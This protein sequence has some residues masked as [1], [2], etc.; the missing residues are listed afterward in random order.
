MHAR[1][2]SY[3]WNWIEDKVGIEKEK[4]HLGKPHY[5]RRRQY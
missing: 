2:E 4:N 5:R 3:L 1:E